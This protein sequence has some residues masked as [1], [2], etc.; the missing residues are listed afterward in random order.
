M[1]HKCILQ[2]C[3]FLS[4][5]SFANTWFFYRFGGPSPKVWTTHRW[6]ATLLSQALGR[7]CRGSGDPE[8]ASELARWAANGRPG[9]VATAR[10]R[11]RKRS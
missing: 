9:K 11:W 2:I 3:L 5:S 1:L 8:S 6:E 4:V 10:W 7:N